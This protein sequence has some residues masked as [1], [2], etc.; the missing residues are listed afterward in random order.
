MRLC[1]R[2]NQIG[3]QP[4]GDVK[5]VAKP[6]FRHET[7]V[8]FGRE[9][10]LSPTM[11]LVIAKLVVCTEEGAVLLCKMNHLEI[12]I[13]PAVLPYT[14]L[15]KD[16]SLVLVK[17]PQNLVPVL[18]I[19]QPV[20][21]VRPRLCLLP[22]PSVREPFERPFNIAERHE[23]NNVK[24]LPGRMP[25]RSENPTGARVHLA[26]LL[27]SLTK[28][29]SHRLSVRPCQICSIQHDWPR[30]TLRNVHAQLFEL[31]LPAEQRGQVSPQRLRRLGICP[32]VAWSAL[33]A[34]HWSTA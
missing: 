17:L 8:L 13:F 31:A 15:H 5:F 10:E 4:G 24:A 11:L 34:R 21:V 25:K 33:V 23:G 29:C 28:S 12:V 30:R 22:S 16:K 20:H 9:P 27:L 26:R 32:Y 6:S 7:P 18:T 19:L 1:H 2:P 3:R 14:T